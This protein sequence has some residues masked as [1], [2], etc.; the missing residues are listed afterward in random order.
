MHRV[1]SLLEKSPLLQTDITEQLSEWSATHTGLLRNVIVFTAIV[2]VLLVVASLI[3]RRQILNQIREHDRIEKLFIVS[4]F[5]TIIGGVSLFGISFAFIGL[6]S[7]GEFSLPGLLA[8]GLLSVVVLLAFLVLLST[9]V[10]LAVRLFISMKPTNP[11]ITGE[12]TWGGT[13]ILVITLA[14]FLV[15][16][17]LT[18]VS[19]TA[20]SLAGSA[21]FMVLPLFLVVKTYSRSMNTLGFKKPIV[22]LLVF[23]LPLLPILVY[24]NGW[25]YEI[26]EK[27]IGQF[28]LEDLIKNVIA[29]N[30]LI[31]SVHIGVVG[32]VG[33]EIF[34]RGFAYN[35]FKRKYGM[36]K[37][38]LFSALFFGFYHGIPW[39]IPY[40]F[41]AGCILAYVY[42]KTQSIYSPILFHIINNSVS[43]IGTWT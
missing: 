14:Y 15:S 19:A 23:S 29:E 3:R 6:Q 42:E 2:D 32:P 36:S 22:K 24:G 16:T 20:G 12:V 35:A 18:F 8:A 28:A 9:F 5:T 34:F 25:V 39:Q 4:F 40:A 7:A 41:V 38:I 17:S 37:G 1:L 30:P 13:P 43:I 33:E 26:T 27:V 31:M 10:I 21:V 11:L